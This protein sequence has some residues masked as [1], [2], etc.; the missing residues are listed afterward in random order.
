MYGKT[1]L[2]GNQVNQ[3]F[4]RQV[5]CSQGYRGSFASVTLCSNLSE[6]NDSTHLQS[7]ALS[8]GCAA[9]AFVYCQI[10]GPHL[11]RWFSPYSEIQFCGHATLAAADVLI[12][13]INTRQGALHFRSASHSICVKR[14]TSGH[15]VM[16]LPQCTL[17]ASLD[18]PDVAKIFS[19]EVTNFHYTE[20]D[21]GYL[22]A[23]VPNRDHVANFDFASDRYC[24]LT[25]RAL[26]ITAQ[27]VSQPNTVYFRYFAPQ[28]GSKEDAAT[29][30]AAPLLAALWQLPINRTLKC[31]Q[32][33]SQGAFYRIS[34]SDLEVSVFASVQTPL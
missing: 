13:A 14:V 19:E 27:D 23:Q 4:V 21:D 6:F 2:G 24:K 18:L 3:T 29:G 26:L 25:R 8:T 33:S 5:F 30:S 20:P 16:L 9:T 32:L 10:D 34:Q 7:R 17:R 11:I 15:Y 22:V 31:Y 1:H 28:Y 12:T